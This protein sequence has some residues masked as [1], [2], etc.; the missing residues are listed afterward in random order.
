MHF[1]EATSAHFDAVIEQQGPVG[2]E[3]AL[4]VS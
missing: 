4:S 1:P 2:T 3:E